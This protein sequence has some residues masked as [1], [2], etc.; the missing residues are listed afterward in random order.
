MNLFDLISVD[1]RLR[2]CDIILVDFNGLVVGMVAQYCEE[3]EER[4]EA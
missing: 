2:R 3:F 1:V 4:R